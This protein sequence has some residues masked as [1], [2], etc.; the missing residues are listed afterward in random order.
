MVQAMGGGTCFALSRA[1]VRDV[2]P[3]DEAA[4]LIGYIA[5]AMVVAPM[6]APLVGGFLDAHFGWRSIFYVMLAM[7]APVTLSAWLLLT[8]TV[9]RGADSSL[10][11]ILRA[12]PTLVADRAFFG[13]GLGLAFPTAA[14]FMFIAG[15]P[16][17]V[18]TVMGGTAATYGAYFLFN[19]GGY[20]VGNFVTGRFGRRLG[21]E[22]L[23]LA[24]TALSL[25]SVTVAL[26]FALLGPWN[27]ATLFVPLA[28]NAIGNGLTIPGGTAL[29]LSVRPDLAG[30]AAGLVG[31]LQLGL[32]ALGAVVV[33]YTVQVWPP[34]LVVGM[35]GFVLAG[36][37]ALVLARTAPGS[38]RG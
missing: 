23:V 12:F 22:R 11:A 16:Y 34:S 19:A 10:G 8:E 38:P 29:A 26:G 17:L 28:L 30:T 36:I 33:G 13:Y 37:A 20:M 3:K 14:F 31:A 6:V 35:L 27:P 32:G 24:G 4:S 25:I 18:V 5:T 21:G 1:V 9:P 2:A 15:A 7:A